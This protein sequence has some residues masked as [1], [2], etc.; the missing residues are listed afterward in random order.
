MNKKVKHLILK[1]YQK[2][3]GK[4][5]SKRIISL[6][7]KLAGI[8]LLIFAYN[9]IGIFDFNEK[10]EENFI[11]N[12]LKLFLNKK[13]DY[14]FFDVGANVGNYTKLLL[15]HIP[16]CKVYSFEPNINTFKI[17][18]NTFQNQQNVVCI[19][20]GLG[21][22]KEQKNLFFYKN[23]NT[24]AHSSIYE[25]VF[26]DL[27]KNKSIKSETVQ[28]STLNDFVK[29]NNISYIDFIK[30]DTEGCEYNVLKG[31]KHFIEE[32]N[33]GII[34]FEFNEM[35]IVSKI[36]LRD[37][38]ALLLNYSFYRICKKGLILL[39]DYNS[40]NEIF[41]YQNIIAINNELCQNLNNNIC[42]SEFA[43]PN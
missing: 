16:N 32:N 28:I 33:I 40:T 43:I 14:V 7:S 26:I 35:N 31:A 21:D 15:K 10:D 19:N 27:H 9:E 42:C 17:L 13:D 4:K 34:Q 30:I 39:G 12:I 18:I 22:Y 25:N 1:I 24:T 6:I 41:K 29:D 38:Y 3:I 8:N 5:T 23:D 37:F 11:E 20:K 2:I 36:F